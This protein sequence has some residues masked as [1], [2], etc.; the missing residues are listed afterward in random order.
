[1]NDGPDG[2]T[3][4]GGGGVRAAFLLSLA[5]GCGDQGAAT[6]TDGG[7]PVVPPTSDATDTPAAPRGE[8]GSV[9]VIQRQARHPAIPAD[10]TVAAVFTDSL[11]NWVNLPAC[12]SRR[13]EDTYCL[14]ELP[15]LDDTWESAQPYDDSILDPLVTRR[16]GDE[17][18]IGPWSIP[19][20][21]DAQA[22][23]GSYFSEVTGA[24]SGLI[25][26][27]FEGDD[28][29]A[30]D[31]GPVLELPTLATVT[32]PD[33]TAFH[34]FTSEGPV[35]VRWEPGTGDVFLVLTTFFEERV[36]RLEDDGVY[37]LDLTDVE[38]LDGDPVD[39]VLIRWNEAELLSGTDELGF[40]GI[41]EQWIYGSYRDLGGRVE[42][43]ANDLCVDAVEG[44][45][46]QPGTYW[47]TTLGHADNLS[48]G[49]CTGFPSLGP[50]G[51][52]RVSIPPGGIATF[53]YTL[54]SDDASLYLVTN[55]VDAGTCLVGSDSTYAS[56]TETVAWYNDTPDP[57]D[58]VLVLDAFKLSGLPAVT[59][60]F[61]L[62]YT[63]SVVGGDILTD[64]CAEAIS[65][66]PVGTGAFAGDLSGAAND[67]SPVAPCLLTPAQGGEG[68]AKVLVEDGQTLTVTAN[69]PDSDTALYLV[70]NCVQAASCL[71][72]ANVAT[73]GPETVTYTNTT[74]GLENIYIVV[75]SVNAAG[76]YNLDIDLN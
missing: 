69:M 6:P 64:T 45:I 49:G 58:A 27:Q 36:Y 31:S 51:F 23:L 34:V 2:V 57:L 37:D 63:L 52:A 7:L 46:L 73:V 21:F 26:V 39:L 44:D 32:E 61:V 30:F 17:L 4:A 74:G 22:Q 11:R 53:S 70:Y 33:P 9:M 62:D 75:D 14:D 10:V 24:S 42:L 76:P 71:L 29:A 12:L 54:P 65:A 59:D 43:V 55:C 35:P 40:I 48:G 25:G 13:A 16:V 15:V 19:W 72:G 68:F 41:S 3:S 38:L 18:I 47:G 1:M 67:L 66:L 28:W 20:S 50:E 60:I 56:G 5:T 8:E